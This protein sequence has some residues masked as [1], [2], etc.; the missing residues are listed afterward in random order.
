ADGVADAKKEPG[1][2]APADVHEAERDVRA[3][4]GVPRQSQSAG[5]IVLEAEA[6]AGFSHQ[7]Q[8][9]RERVLETDEF[10]DVGLVTP[11]V[12]RSPP[13]HARVGGEERQ[14]VPLEVMAGVQ[15]DKRLQCL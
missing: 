8:S 2:I 11:I 10:A 4:R 14:A 15:G 12:A 7:P 3:I 13:L 1:C 9:W 5:S 6:G